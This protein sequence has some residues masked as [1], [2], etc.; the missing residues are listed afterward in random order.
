MVYNKCFLINNLKIFA[1]VFKDGTIYEC[2][3]GFRH[4]LNKIDM[5]SNYAI[6]NSIY[7]R[8]SK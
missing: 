1:V 3:R 7:S 8:L 2:G 6:I 5:D 4:L